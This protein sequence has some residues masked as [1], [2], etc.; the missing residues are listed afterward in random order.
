MKKRPKKLEVR[1]EIVR[2]MSRAELTRAVGGDS[3]AAACSTTV[4]LV[5]PPTRL[6][7]S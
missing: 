3:E 2:E 7:K 1:A 6:P 5:V 4:H